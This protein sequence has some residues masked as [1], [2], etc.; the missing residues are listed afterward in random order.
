MNVILQSRFLSLVFLFFSE[1]SF[2]LSC[3]IFLW[4]VSIVSIYTSVLEYN[5]CIFFFI[6]YRKSDFHVCSY[7][8][9]VFSRLG[10]VLV[11][12]SNKLTWTWAWFFFNPA[13]I[14]NNLADFC[15]NFF[16]L[17]VSASISSV[18]FSPS[19]FSKIFFKRLL[20]IL[21]FLSANTAP[22][23]Y[24]GYI[25]KSFLILGNHW[26]FCSLF[27]PTVVSI[28]FGFLFEELRMFSIHFFCLSTFGFEWNCPC[29]SS[30]IIDW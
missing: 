7:N 29:K 24:N 2:C 28:V 3:K 25:V 30:P 4:W 21:V 18:Q 22:L 15:S 23:K 16:Y 12:R 1:A 11:F 6:T 26:I 19:F 5:L 17:I 9:I 14:G 20:L 13:C 8:Q 27:F 10:F